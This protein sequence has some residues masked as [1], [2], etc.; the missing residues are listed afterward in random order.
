[1]HHLYNMQGFADISFLTYVAKFFLD[2][3]LFWLQIQIF[4]KEKI[5]LCKRYEH[6]Y[7]SS[8]AL[9]INNKMTMMS[10]LAAVVVAAAAAVA[11]AVAVDV[12]VE[13]TIDCLLFLRK[14]TSQMMVNP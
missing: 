6:Y 14:K 10:N 5:F 3:Y 8:I 13:V 12:V 11:V 2:I 7:Y 9:L 1:M 4:P